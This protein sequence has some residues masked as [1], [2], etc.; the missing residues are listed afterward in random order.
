M[1]RRG[2][3]LVEVDGLRYLMLPT[4]ALNGLA[5]VSGPRTP[6][7]IAAIDRLG[8][9]LAPKLGGIFICCSESFRRA[10]G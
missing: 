7:V 3:E 6:Q 5:Y 9:T 8:N 2:L 10:D 4:T 1:Q